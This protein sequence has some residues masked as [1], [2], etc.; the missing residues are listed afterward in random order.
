MD[1]KSDEQFIILQSTIESN[2]QDMKS[3]K[4]ESDEKMMNLTEYLKAMIESTIT[5]TVG[6][7]NI[8]K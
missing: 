3:N 1:N 6:Q 8:Y 2:K 7:M 5:S 4:Q